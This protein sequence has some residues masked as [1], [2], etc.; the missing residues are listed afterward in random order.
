MKESL[1]LLTHL[2]TLVFAVSTMAA[3]GL[4]LKLNDIV[5]PLKDR[6]L[7]LRSLLVNFVLVPLFALLIIWLLPLKESIATGLMLL[8]LAPGEPVLP[9]LAK[10]AKVNVGFSVELAVMLMVGTIFYLPLVFPLFVSGVEINTL[11][12]AKELFVLMLLPLVFG[13]IINA[14][15]EGVSKLLLPTL[16]QTSNIT[17]ILVTA[18]L[19]FINF[20]HVVGLI[21]T[22]G[23]LAML[24]LFT[25]GFGVGYL[26]GG[27]DRDKRI[28]L[29]MGTPLRNIPAPLLIA[30]QNFDDPNVAVMV[31]V[32]SVLLVAM[33]PVAGEIGLQSKKG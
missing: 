12:V 27:P 6:R 1:D 4:S 3:T 28:V 17:L 33:L 23:I 13:L 7:V 5:E 25:S 24:L 29:A 32:A 8:A 16:E 9:K 20:G 31:V 15:Y 10:I 14:R 30:T 19:L 11:L 26:F 21:G 2:M 18:L 22:F